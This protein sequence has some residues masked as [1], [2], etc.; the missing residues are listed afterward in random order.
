MPAQTWAWH[1]SIEQYRNTSMA[2]TFDFDIDKYPPIP[3]LR[4]LFVTG[5]DTGVGKTLIAGA[6]A[7]RLRQLGRRV[8]VFK[9]VATGCPRKAG[10]GLVSEDA[11]FLAACAESR[12]TLAEIAPI[13]YATAVAPNVAAARERRPVDLQTIFDAYSSLAGSFTGGSSFSGEPK[14][15]PVF[16]AD[17][18]DACP[19]EIDAVIVEGVGGLLCPI[20]DDF[21]V[22]HFA[23]MTALPLVIVARPGL[24]TINHTLLTLHAARTAGLNVAGVVVNDYLLEPPYDLPLPTTSPRRQGKS[25]RPSEPPFRDDTDIAMFHNPQEIAARGK[26]NVLAVV[27]HEEQNSVQQA[28]IGPDTE[29]NIAQVPWEKLIGR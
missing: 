26:V 5:T 22:I 20:T 3:R 23:R 1:P 19:T 11:E 8:E 10:L 15:S 28:T 2:Q 24:G 14:A 16:N 6:I 7:R 25:S 18:R 21:W 27:P 9:P 12:R 29:F 13:C 4:G 17:R